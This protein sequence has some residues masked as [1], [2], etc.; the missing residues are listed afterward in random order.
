[1]RVLIVAHPLS[2]AAIRRHLRSAAV[3]E[4]IEGYADGRRPCS[5]IV[6]RARPDVVLVDEMG[7][8]LSALARVREIRTTVPNAKVVL[9]ADRMAPEWLTE[10]SAAG[11]H[12]AVAKQLRAASLGMLVR[13]VAAGNVFHAFSPTAAKPAS[14]HPDLTDRELEILRLVAAGASNSAIGAQLW[15]TEP[16]VKFHLSNVYRKLNVANRTQASHYAYVNG[17]LAIPPPT[18]AGPADTPVSVAA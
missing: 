5:E 12:A 13:E 8:P 6:A 14:N 15:V 1:M 2:A 7:A 3:H 17:L 18:G 4:L 9:L 16:T 11:V 10:A